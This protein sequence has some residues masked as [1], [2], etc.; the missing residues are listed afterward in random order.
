MQLLYV[1]ATRAWESL[2][3][4]CD[5]Q[6][7]VRQAAQRDSR[8]LLALDLR[9]EVSPQERLRRENVAPSAAGGYR[10]ENLGGLEEADGMVHPSRA[11]ASA[12]ACPAAAG[13]TGAAG[14]RA[15]VMSDDKVIDFGDAVQEF[16]RKLDQ[17]A[18]SPPAGL[19]E[20]VSPVEVEPD[21]HG[22][23]KKADPMPETPH[24]PYRPHAG[25]LNRLQAGQRTFY[26]VFADCTFHGLPYAH[27]DGIRLQRADS[28]A[29]GLVLV[30]RFSGSVVEEVWI[31]G[32]NLRYVATCIGLGIM[33]WIWE[34]PPGRQTTSDADCLITRITIKTCDR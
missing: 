25:Y 11:A 26:C 20:P 12:V 27:Y 32:Q 22:L 24:E 10:R 9:P 6:G 1:A 15:G 23:A 8:Q 16:F 29:G 3:A 33:P 5:D 17:P 14:A 30:V 34:M 31:E 19:A 18:A 21:R 4:Y 28:P 2:R 13:R 7:D